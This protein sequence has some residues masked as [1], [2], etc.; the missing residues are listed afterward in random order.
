MILVMGSLDIGM[1]KFTF[2]FKGVY[3]YHHMEIYPQQ[4]MFWL[5]VLL[6]HPG[7]TSMW[8]IYQHEVQRLSLNHVV[9]HNTYH[10]YL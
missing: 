2:I 6:H 4:T 7:T 1:Y 3:K 10:H 9:Y 5:L 8:L